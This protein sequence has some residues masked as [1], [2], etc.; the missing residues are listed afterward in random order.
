[1]ILGLPRACLFNENKMSV[2]NIKKKQPK[3][4]LN[5]PTPPPQNPNKYTVTDQKY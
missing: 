4:T 3:K 2:I 1:M 5:P